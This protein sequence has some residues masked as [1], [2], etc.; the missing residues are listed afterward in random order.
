VIHIQPDEGISLRFGAKMPG[1]ALELGAVDMAFNY[2]DY[3]G[4]TPST[5]YETLLYECMR[6]DST[7]FQRA[8][9]VEAGWTRARAVLD[10]WNALPPRGFPN[11]GP[12]PGAR[13]KRT[14]CWPA[15]GRKWQE[16]T[17]LRGEVEIALS[18]PAIRV[19]PD[20][21][22]LAAAAADGIRARAG[23]PPRQASAAASRWPSPAVRRRSGS[24]GCWRGE[25]T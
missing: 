24:T 17:R 10:V 8:D 21:D 23:A 6:G 2:A 5:G 19:L 16:P 22:H 12:A 9:A 3:F 11:Y 4:S 25:D 14:S 20:P 15:N 13:R 1:P 18:A 7:L